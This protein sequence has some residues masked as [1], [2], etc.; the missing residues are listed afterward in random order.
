MLRRHTL[1][2]G[3][4]VLVLTLWT[5]RVSATDPTIGSSC[6][7]PGQGGLSERYDGTGNSWCNGSTW[8]YPTYVLGSTST[9]C[10]SGS[11]GMMQYTGGTFE[12]CNGSSWGSLASSSSVA[13]SGLTAATGSNTIT[14]N[15]NYAQTWSWGTLAGNTALALTTTDL[16]TGTILQVENTGANNST[17]Y[18][19]YFENITTGAGYGLYALTT[20]ASDSGYGLYAQNGGSSNTGYAIYGSNSASGNTG[21][22][23]YLTNAGTGTSYGLYVT[24]A[25]TGSGYG[26]YAS[27][28]G[29]STGYTIYA[30]NAATG[31]GY[32]IYSN[33]SAANTGYAIYSTSAATGTAWGIYSAI[34]G[35]SNTGYAGYFSNAPTTNS[36]VNYG[37]YAT[38]NTTG[39]G[40][41]V[42][43]AMTAANTGYALY[44]TNAATG[45]GYGVYANM[46]AA[47]TGYAVYATNAATGTGYGVLG[48]VTGAANTGYG[49]YFSDTATTANYGV[50][51]TTASKGVGY[52]HY[53]SIT[54]HG[55]TGYAGYFSNTDTGADANYGVYASNASASGYGGYFTNT[56]TGY[57]GYFNGK[58][59]A[60]SSVQVGSTTATCA[61]GNAGAVQYTSGTLEACNGTSWIPI[62]SGM[63]LIETV[64]ASAASSLQV[65]GLPG[66]Y[67]TIFINCTGLYAPVGFTYFLTYLGE[68]STTWETG[69]NYTCN[70]G[71]VDNGNS[72]TGCSG[73]TNNYPVYTGDY[74]NTAASNGNSYKIWIDNPGSSS[75]YKMVTYLISE[76]DV[77]SGG[78]ATFYYGNSWWNNDTNPI[79]GFEF[80][81]TG[82]TG[83]SCTISGTCTAYGM[84]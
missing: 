48:S 37:I 26:I 61:A 62:D 7:S 18:A 42:Y 14:G 16:T 34:T 25:T 47:N 60:S 1:I 79:T 28:T 84:N 70:M 3:A 78:Y 59:V 53:S 36:G 73:S 81:P 43:T 72:S 23:G 45:T 57:A 31:T 49:G 30:T 83:G 58:V 75:V 77:N 68:G 15:G 41:G 56:S 82:C 19:G 52:G 63:H 4:I 65:T 13:L 71:A 32:G 33:M 6:T 24:D 64:T 12:G 27:L 55:N 74:V 2:R 44:A 66:T 9:G 39:S 67:N 21:Y 38:D 5:C 51:S 46:S 40:Y 20:G 11:A 54:G 10:N 69:A 50:Y 80:V 29:A 35:N 8:Q 22:A 17:G 76:N